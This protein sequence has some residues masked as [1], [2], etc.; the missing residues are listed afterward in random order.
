MAKAGVYGDAGA[1]AQALNNRPIAVG[2]DWSIQSAGDLPDILSPSDHTYVS[3]KHVGDPTLAGSGASGSA[4][5]QGQVGSRLRTMAEM[6]QAWPRPWQSP[7]QIGPNNTP[8]GVSGAHVDGTGE[9]GGID[10]GFAPSVSLAVSARKVQDGGG[11][12]PPA[13]VPQLIKSTVREWAGLLQHGMTQT[14]YQMFMR[15]ESFWFKQQYQARKAKSISGSLFTQG[16]TASRLRIPAVF[17]PRT[18]S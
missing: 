5:S 6:L 3:A 15:H 9:R 7:R 13:R 11:Q 18:I 16:P 2:R 17:V 1:S 4:R 12:G 8:S 10:Y 14:Q